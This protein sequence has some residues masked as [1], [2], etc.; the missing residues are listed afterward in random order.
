M[1]RT[2]LDDPAPADIPAHATWAPVINRAQSNQALQ[3]PVELEAS[4]T[5]RG[6]RIPRARARMAHARER[7]PLDWAMTRDKKVG[8]A[9][10]RSEE[11]RES[12]TARLE[13]RRSRRAAGVH[14]QA[15]ALSEGTWLRGA[16]APV[17]CGAASD[18]EK[19]YFQGGIG[20]GC[21]PEK[22]GRGVLPRSANASFA[23]AQFGD[24]SFMSRH[25]CRQRIFAIDKI[26]LQ[27]HD[28]PASLRQ[29]GFENA[30]QTGQTPSRVESQS[31]WHQCA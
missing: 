10:M 11:A 18:I 8:N 31:F 2:G 4:A 3:V 28:V 9:P 21:I 15:G 26:H 5:V 19:S 24:G 13:V 23:R 29:P 27:V 14:A 20:D 7:I 25:E 1:P 16:A 17:C 6:V 22:I 30:L 12:G